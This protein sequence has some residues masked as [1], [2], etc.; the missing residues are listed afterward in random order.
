[1]TLTN[2]LGPSPFVGPYR[3]C[4]PIPETEE[5]RAIVADLILRGVVPF[6]LERL[7]R[8]DGGVY[9]RWR[10]KSI[11]PYGSTVFYTEGANGLPADPENPFGGTDVEVTILRRIRDRANG[12]IF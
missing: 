7:R 9:E 12:R 5:G 8:Q 1:M 4:P 2:T 3:Q 6:A 11:D 10:F